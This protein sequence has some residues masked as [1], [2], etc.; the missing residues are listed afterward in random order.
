MALKNYPGLH[1]LTS[2]DFFFFFFLFFFF[3]RNLGWISRKKIQ[4]SSFSSFFIFFSSSS[5]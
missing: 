5:F 3:W 1:L 4:F 2:F